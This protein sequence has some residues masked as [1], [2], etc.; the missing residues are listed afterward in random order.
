VC[1]RLRHGTVV[2]LRLRSRRLSA[3]TPLSRLP[4]RRPKQKQKN[5]QNFLCVPEAKLLKNVNKM[6]QED[7]WQLL[8]KVVTLVLF[9]KNLCNQI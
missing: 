4:N 2:P 3:S 7:Y 6:S 5:N 8:A 9:G 1:F